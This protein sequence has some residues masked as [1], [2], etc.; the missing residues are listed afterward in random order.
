LTVIDRFVLPNDDT[1]ARRAR[2]A[3][4]TTLKRWHLYGLIDDAVL[5]VSELTTNAVRHGLPPILLFVRRGF[6]HVRIDV[7]DARPDGLAPR[8]DPAEF[9]ES[10]RGLDI[11]SSVSDE[12]GSESIPDD[13][14]TVYACWN[15]VD[16]TGTS[17]PGPV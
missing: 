11:V 16:A 2:N 12:A 5:A 4:R 9:R 1:A 13:G 7:G 10:G 17:S 15:V 14:K 6:A 8:Q 3:V